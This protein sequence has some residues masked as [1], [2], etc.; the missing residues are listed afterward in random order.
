MNNLILGLPLGLS[1]VEILIHIFNFAVLMVAVRFLLWK[2]VKKNIDRRRLEHE[3]AIEESKKMVKEAEDF[4]TEYRALVENIEK[5]KTDIITKALLEAEERADA[6]IVKSKEQ[7][8]N[9]IENAKEIVKNN[10][11]Q[12]QKDFEK[13]IAGLAIDI[14][15]KVVEREISEKDNKKLIENCLSQ[16]EKS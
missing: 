15:S 3:K 9:I 12:A 10:R 5:E 7:A 14:A 2:P 13:E 11:A 8:E 1:L 4:K 16:W 6:I